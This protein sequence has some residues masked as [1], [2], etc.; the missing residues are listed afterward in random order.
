[1][2]GRIKKTLWLCCDHALLN[3]PRGGCCKKTL[4]YNISNPWPS[5]TLTVDPNRAQTK[6]RTSAKRAQ[7]KPKPSA[8][9]DRAVN[10]N[11][12]KNSFAGGFDAGLLTSG[13]CYW[14]YFMTKHSCQWA[15][16]QTPPGGLRPPV[17]R[18]VKKTNRKHARKQSHTSTETK[19]CFFL[20][21]FMAAAKMLAIISN[22]LSH[23]ASVKS[24]LHK[25]AWLAQ[26][27]GLRLAIKC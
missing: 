8:H 21:S 13:L 15:S 23:A 4:F 27:A 9:L 26:L 12:V 25:Q 10:K 16:S 5:T 7:T 19:Y 20:S 11:L 2:A 22:P 18:Q 1:M 24:E 17:P 14:T 3:F 6:A